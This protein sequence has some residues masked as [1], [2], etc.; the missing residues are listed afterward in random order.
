MQ[1]FGFFMFRDS[2]FA[3]NQPD[4]AVP[5]GCLL[6]VTL[7]ILQLLED[8]IFIISCAELEHLATA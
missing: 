3:H 7:T 4:F 2:L 8:A 6:N 1:K 5:V